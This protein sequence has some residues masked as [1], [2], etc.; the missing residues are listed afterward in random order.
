MNNELYHHGIKGQKWGI[1]RYQNS[2][3]TLTAAGKARYGAHVENVSEKRLL[4]QMKKYRKSDS[5]AITAIDERWKK[6]EN[7]AAKSKAGKKLDETNKLMKEL[8]RQI[9][10]QHG[11]KAEV[12]YGQQFVDEY[13][14]LV[15]DMR[16]VA[17]DYMN[18]PEFRDK[19]ASMYLSELGYDDTDAGRE[20]IKKLM[21]EFRYA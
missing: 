17:T 12:L 15:S 3:G 2:D 18:K 7:L 16:K 4:N 13:N 21:G 9:K 14:R 20:Y 8:D 10:E 1:R 19:V 11:P 6:A 5:K